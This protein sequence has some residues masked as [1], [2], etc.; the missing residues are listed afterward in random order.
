MQDPTEGSSVNN[1]SLIHGSTRTADEFSGYPFQKLKGEG[2]YSKAYH[3]EKKR[4][5]IQPL[6][7]KSLLSTLELATATPTPNVQDKGSVAS[8]LKS[9]MM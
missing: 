2:Q 7:S 4:P 6:K 3:E 8:D 1:K 5:P 9:S